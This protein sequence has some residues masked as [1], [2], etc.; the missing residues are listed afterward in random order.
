MKRRGAED[1]IRPIAERQPGQFHTR[2]ANAIAERGSEIGT[3]GEEHVPG[4]IDG[5]Q[6]TARKPFHHVSREPAGP[7]T[8]VDHILV[9]A[10]L[11]A[12][13]NAASPLGLWA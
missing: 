11:Q 10:K 13:E 3:C 8:G 2:K 9:A 7:A 4:A 12:R 5:D 6:S 1:E